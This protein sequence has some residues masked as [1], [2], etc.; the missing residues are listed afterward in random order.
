[1]GEDK[2]LASELEGN[3]G[4]VENIDPGDRHENS[5]SRFLRHL[6][7][8]QRGFLF[9]LYF[10][11]GVPQACLPCLRLFSCLEQSASYAGV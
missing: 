7:V 9:S 11:W 1:M 5:A 10:S 3:K 2:Q 6:T 4:K 8:R